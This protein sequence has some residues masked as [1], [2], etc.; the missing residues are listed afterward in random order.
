M[1]LI[2]MGN[3]TD[4][5]AITGT[6][7]VKNENDNHIINTAIYNA[8]TNEVVRSSTE[9]IKKDGDSE[10]SWSVSQGIYEVRITAYV[11]MIYGGT[12]KRELKLTKAIAAGE[13][14]RFTYDKNGKFT[15]AKDPPS[16]T[17]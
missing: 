9:W 5:I 3:C 13:T 12:S 8:E 10:K 6:I 11:D 4:Y 2:L 14:W 16:T 1:G 7:I 15:A 17:P